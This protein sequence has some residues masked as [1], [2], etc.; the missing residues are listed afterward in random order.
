MKKKQQ[1][2]IKQALTPNKKEFEVLNKI[3]NGQKQNND[4]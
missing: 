4:A 3:I 1:L 2:R